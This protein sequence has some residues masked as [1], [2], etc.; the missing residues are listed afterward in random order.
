MITPT[1]TP[2]SLTIGQSV[3]GR[4]IKAHHFGE[5]RYKVVLV[6]DIHGGWE[7]NTHELAL[8][9]LAHFKANPHDVPD[10]VS[11]WI[12]PTLNPDG[13]A[14]NTR[15]NARGVD[16]NRNAD[17]DHGLRRGRLRGKR[18][19]RRGCSHHSRHLS[20][21]PDLLRWRRRLVRREPTGW[22]YHH[23]HPQLHPRLRRP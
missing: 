22:R 3:E 21:S 2:T 9:L 17:T 16:L 6:G 11:L 15:V 12:I 1:P 5:G 10:D 7:A 18:Y 23:H 4:S 13:L 14:A 20:R 8:E 19:L